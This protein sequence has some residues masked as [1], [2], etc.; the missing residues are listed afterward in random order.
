MFGHNHLADTI[1]VIALNSA[2]FDTN[3][4]KAKMKQCNTEYG[5][6]RSRVHSNESPNSLGLL[7]LKNS[8]GI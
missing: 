5:I 7:W 3:T 6:E 1:Y 2:L 8:T 4:F